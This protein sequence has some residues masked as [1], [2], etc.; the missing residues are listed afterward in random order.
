[1][2]NKRINYSA[3]F[4]SKVALAALRQEK[5]ISQLASQFKV[6]PVMIG[7]WKS[8]LLSHCEEVFRDGRSRTKQEH[9][10]VEELYQKIGHLEVENDF[11]KKKSEE[12][13][14]S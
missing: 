4:K 12:L 3:S 9:P 11:L 1:M 14:S 10:S 2:P 8:H 13:S 7:K 5:T 6:H